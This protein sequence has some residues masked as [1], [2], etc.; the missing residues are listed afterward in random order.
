[1]SIKIDTEFELLNKLT[2]SEYKVYCLIRLWRNK[3]FGWGEP[4]A[5]YIMNK[6]NKSRAT[7][8]RALAGLKKKGVLDGK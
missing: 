4:D 8:F 2:D 1:M 5:S 6:L 3:R 7:T